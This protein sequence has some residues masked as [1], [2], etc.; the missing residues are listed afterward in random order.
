METF[1]E[2][3]KDIFRFQIAEEIED[4][5]WWMPQTLRWKVILIGKAR[6]KNLERTQKAQPVQILEATLG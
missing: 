1:K 3:I 4:E 6:A 5:R 2:E